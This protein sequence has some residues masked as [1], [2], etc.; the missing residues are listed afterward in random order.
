MS[1]LKIGLDAKRAYQ[2][3]T[4]L[5]NYSRALIEALAKYY[6]QHEYLLFAPK[7]S[8]MFKEKDVPGTIFH[9]P[10]SAFERKL[11]GLWRSRWMTKDLIRENVD[12]YNGLSHE[13]PFGIHKTGIP[14]AVTMHDLIFERYPKQYNPIDVFTYRRKA[15]YACNAADRVIAIS[16]Q[17]K[18]DL[19]QFYHVPSSKIDVV[20]QC[21]NPI[22]EAVWPAAAK[23]SFRERYYL[24]HQYFLYVG[25]IIE[26]KNLLGIIE[27]MHLLGDQ[28]DVPL[29][30]LGQGTTYKK[31]VQAAA[32]EYGLQDRLIWI[33][34]TRK[35]AFHDVPALY[36]CATGLIYPSLF[37]GFGIPILEALWS[38]TP[39]ITSQGSCF[40]ETGGNAAIY[41]DPL[42]HAS[43]AEAMM[44]L[45]TDR[46]MA[47]DMTERGIMHAQKFSAQN[48]AKGVMNTLTAIKR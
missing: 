2:N 21:C 16:E 28:T 29:V 35:L 7:H 4:G 15:R 34:D 32:A 40:S 5:G 23:A 39:V 20:Y 18:E 43:I 6:P 12:V 46:D 47:A 8:Q 37:E 17:T 13:L 31:K 25:S 10:Q 11:K 1:P 33:N 42:N 3:N 22:F 48:F 14:S 19:I 38:K 41:I 44:S 26:R 36:Q 27:A 9:G 24:P 30:I 45:L